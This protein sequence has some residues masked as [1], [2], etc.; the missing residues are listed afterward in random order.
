MVASRKA[1][2]TRWEPEFEPDL[3]QQLA[4]TLMESL[5]RKPGILSPPSISA[6][7]F[8]QSSER[9]DVPLEKP[10][11][12][13][14]V[15]KLRQLRETLDSKDLDKQKSELFLWLSSAFCSPA[16]QA[17]PVIPVPSPAP[18]PPQAPVEPCQKAPCLLANKLSLGSSFWD[19]AHGTNSLVGGRH[20]DSTDRDFSLFSTSFPC[21]NDA[22][23]TAKVRHQS[24]EKFEE[25]TATYYQ[26][27][28]AM[29]FTKKCSEPNLYG[30]PST[31]YASSMTNSPTMS[32]ASPW[33]FS[34]NIL[35][36][37]R[38]CSIA[39]G[40][41]F[42][43]EIQEVIQPAHCMIAPPPGLEH[44]KPQCTQPRCTSPISGNGA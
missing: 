21:R 4:H 31:S 3:K 28:R 35:P 44:L 22:L 1:Q 11:I 5:S 30:T 42:D 40:Q 34:E 6:N 17:P 23:N 15:S 10:P 33:Y 7:V 25:K 9:S 37:P 14:D 43:Q 18:V 26:Q 36:S 39:T 38:P 16:T 20:N 8:K 12:C 41:V 13:I 19:E 27:P 32:P 2:P 29:Q 24:A